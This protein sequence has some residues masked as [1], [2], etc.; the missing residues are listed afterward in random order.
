MKPLFW[1]ARLNSKSLPRAQ[2][3]LFVTSDNADSL[4]VIDTDENAVLARVN[5][6]APRKWVDFTID[7]NDEQLEQSLPL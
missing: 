1:L 7:T 2:N 5:T 3:K 6:S 4:F